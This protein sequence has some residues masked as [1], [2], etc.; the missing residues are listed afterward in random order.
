[1]KVMFYIN[2]LGHGGAERVMVNLAKQFSENGAEVVMATSFVAENEYELSEN[3]RRINILSDYPRNF[4]TRNLRL[5]RCLQR[6]IKAEKPDVVIS[7]MA[8]PNFRAVCACLLTKTKSIISVRNDPDKE[9]PNPVFRFLAKTLYRYADG[10]V[11][12][13]DDA[14]NWFPRAVGK[15]SRI[16]FNQVAEK[17]YNKT[18]TAKKNGIVTV[19]RLTKQKNHKALI[20]A[21]A[22]IADEIADD[23]IIYGDGELRDELVSYAESLGVAHRVLLPGVVDNVECVINN[24]KLF[25]L[26][27]DYEGMPNALMEAMALGVPSVSTDCPCGGPKMLFGD[28]QYLVSVGDEIALADKMLYVLKPEVAAACSL[29]LQARAELFRPGV[30]FDAWK[31][32]VIE[33]LEDK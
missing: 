26:S 31:S 25:V 9:Y 33:V 24:A 8:E 6:I 12:Q 10:V 17:F 19:G 22:K 4:L 13:T 1:M 32:F 3:V 21:Y 29:H 30:V 7:F 27:S 20:A 16:I 15:K 28:D 2:H 23:L 11:F 14:K 5:V 18:S